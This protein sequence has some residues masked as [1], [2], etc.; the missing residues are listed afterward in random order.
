MRI[1]IIEDDERLTHLIKAFFEQRNFHLDVAHDG[2]VGLEMILG[3]GYQVAII[4][5]MLPGRDGLSICR[6]IRNTKHAVALLILTA[7]T[8]VEE[9]IAGLD[10]GAD[11]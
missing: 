6:S 4:D 9:R 11:D 1:L 7:R 5:W 8:Q 2:N 3:G 10:S